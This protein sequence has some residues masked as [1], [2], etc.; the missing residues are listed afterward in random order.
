MANKMKASLQLH[1]YK[2]RTPT[3][4][5]CLLYDNAKTFNT[6]QHN[7]TYFTGTVDKL[8]NE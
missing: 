1:Q 3:H 2:I 5:S 6:Y 8:Q 7:Y 4:E